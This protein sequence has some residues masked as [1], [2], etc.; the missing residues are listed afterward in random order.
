M[1]FNLVHPET[2]AGLNQKIH[3][4]LQLP[5]DVSVRTY[6]G[7][8]HAA[9]ELCVG[10][11]LFLSHKRSVAALQ[12]QTYAFQTVLPFLYKEAFQ[13]QFQR[14]LQPK[15]VL[16]EWAKSLKP[17]N[18][19]VMQA[20]DNPITGDQFFD[21]ELEN[22][23]H[24][25]KILSFRASHQK[26]FKALSWSERGLTPSSVQICEISPDLAVAICGS[27]LKS[28]VQ[29]SSYLTWNIENV[30]Q[31]LKSFLSK[32]KLEQSGAI[33]GFKKM[34]PQGFEVFETKESNLQDRVLIFN[35]EINGEAL[36]R[37]LRKRLSLS[38]SSDLVL[39]LSSCRHGFVDL[40]W[41]E[42]KPPHENLRGLIMMSG[43]LIAQSNLAQII[44]ESAQA[45]QL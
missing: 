5:S 23:F 41:W 24:D 32:E 14:Q 1:N 2:W 28:P 34:L 8:H 11:A 37:A 35:K 3:E 36:E 13:L 33:D 18:S 30:L 17:D 19:F 16:I 39:S 22:I 38:E 12:G 31:E 7:I 25:K 10:T 44:S 27:R 21:T 4:L 42:S 26:H 45:C 9:Y 40:S 20:E 6:K 29:I 15:A 43:E